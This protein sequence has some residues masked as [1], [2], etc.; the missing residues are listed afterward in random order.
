MGGPRAGYTTQ[1]RDTGRA[2]VNAA[3]VTRKVGGGDAVDMLLA[4]SNALP[5]MHN[6]QQ[7]CVL[8]SS[9]GDCVP[10]E[11]LRRVMVSAWLAPSAV[12]IPAKN[13]ALRSD[14]S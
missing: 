7:S 9:E 10:S 4:N 11:T 8:S 2:E 6:L 1:A 12:Q 3:S 5:V 13:F 14:L